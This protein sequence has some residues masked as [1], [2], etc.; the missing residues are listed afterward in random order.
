VDFLGRGLTA[1]GRRL[2]HVLLPHFERRPL[3]SETRPV[4]LHVFEPTFIRSMFLY[5][6]LVRDKIRF[7]SNNVRKI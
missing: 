3:A 5:A 2:L 6:A 7:F 4:L 1:E